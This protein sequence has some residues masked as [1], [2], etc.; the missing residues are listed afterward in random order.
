MKMI[1]AVIQ[2]N[3]YQ[4]VREALDRAAVTRL[5]IC[6]AMGIGRQRGEVEP[7]AGH[8][9][10]TVLRPKIVLEIVVNDDFVDRTIDTI[11][12]IATTG[13]SGQIDDGKIFVVPTLET[14]RVS[15]LS[16]GFGAV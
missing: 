6:D 9:F 3:K 8:E 10:S 2:P 11:V 1:I 13:S 5:T 7:D 12:A 4:A 14:I 15:D 16:R